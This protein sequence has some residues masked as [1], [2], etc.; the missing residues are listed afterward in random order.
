VRA[1]LRSVARL[2]RDTRGNILTIF[3]IALPMMLGTLGMAVEGANWYQA[4]QALQNAADEAVV[5][6]ATNNSANYLDEAK[7]VAAQY[8][9]THGAGNVA[10]TGSNA[11]ACPAGGNN[12]F[13]VTIE[14]KLPLLLTAVLG[15]GGNTTIG[16]RGAQLI[17]ATAIATRQ[18]APRKYCVLALATSAPTEDAI[19]FN[20]NGGPKA[21]LSGCSVMS[22]ASMNCN[23]HDLKAEYGDAHG[24]SSGC[25]KEQTSDV[26]VITDK[27]AALAA[28]IPDNTCTSYPQ[29]P[30]KNNDPALP[31][32]NK[33]S[34]SKALGTSTF[35]G[36]LQLTGNVT[37]TGDNVIVIRNG[38]LD[39]NGFSI[40]TASGASAVIIF[41]GQN[42]PYTHIPTGGGEINISSPTSGTWSG[43]AMYTDPSLTSG[44]NITD[45]G[46]KPSWNV[47]GLAYFPRAAVTFS[48]VVGKATNGKACF[49]MVVDKITING[50]GSILSRGE[51]DQQG[52]DMPNSQMPVRGRLVA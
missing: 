20:V 1:A 19:A 17:T 3:A 2:R 42:G 34:G 48:G 27:Y 44:V 5:A 40:T 14:Q 23:G 7:A 26:P 22:N 18:T 9:Y 8:G 49:V 28:Q 38:D 31:A 45:A 15:Y 33:L 24:S 52:L 36:D 21:D 43:I 12:C 29:A 51:C 41:A 32:S 25:G 13:S 11:A 10:I 6:A 50:T 30:T 46:N 37:L 47:S 4:R 39:T 35:C 16:T